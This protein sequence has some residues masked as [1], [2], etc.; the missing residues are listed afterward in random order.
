MLRNLLVAFFFFFF[1]SSFNAFVHQGGFVRR[2]KT[3]N[4]CMTSERFDLTRFGN[5]FG[6]L[7]GAFGVAA[8]LL[9]VNE[10]ALAAGDYFKKLQSP[11]PATTKVSK[12]SK[13]ISPVTQSAEDIKLL[14][15]VAKL[16]KTN[17]DVKTPAT[18]VKASKMV[19]K[20]EVPKS[21][22]ARFFFL[23]KLFN[24]CITLHVHTSNTGT[25][26]CSH[27]NQS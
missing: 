22:E 14:E 1:L 5:R 24:H 20:V 16:Q 10:P 2:F 11:S 9:T 12:S 19:K 13:T 21:L 15:S 6:K 23:L 7:M 18:K 27:Q 3:T 4:L 8:S 25:C 26:R 17:V